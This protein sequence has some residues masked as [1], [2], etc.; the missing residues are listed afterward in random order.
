[1]GLKDMFGNKGDSSDG[2]DPATKSEVN[3]EA[4]KTTPDEGKTFEKET[5]FVCI[6]DCYQNM[7]RYI[8]G[9]EIMGRKCPP[10]FMAKPQDKEPNK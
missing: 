4:K 8:K 9:H 3:Q 5:T 6:E 2:K 10:H 7:T 1:M